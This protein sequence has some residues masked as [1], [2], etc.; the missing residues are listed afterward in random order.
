M[1]LK[2]S[3]NG[4]HAIGLF[5]KTLD[6]DLEQRGQAGPKG[7]YDMVLDETTKVVTDATVN[8]ILPLASQPRNPNGAFT[9]A[10]NYAGTFLTSMVIES[11]RLSNVLNIPAHPVLDRAM[12]AESIA[13]R[14]YVEAAKR[15]RPSEMDLW[16]AVSRTTTTVHDDNDNQR[17]YHNRV[18]EFLALCSIQATHKPE[19]TLSDSAL[20]PYRQAM[21][22][23][24]T[25]DA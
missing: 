22:H 8:D 2:Q 7:A 25:H 17:I 23:A 19:F 5:I 16:S 1:V 18:V 21:L 10:S 14:N 12:R 24:L 11:A 13:L 4:N 9:L 3:V 6:E 15:P 20:L